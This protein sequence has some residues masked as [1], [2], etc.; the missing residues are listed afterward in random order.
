MN[1]TN[2]YESVDCAIL[3]R[4]A[5]AIRDS[6]KIQGTIYKHIKRQ[7]Y[8]D[9]PVSSLMRAAARTFG[10]EVDCVARWKLWPNL[11]RLM[12]NMDIPKCAMLALV[13]TL[14][15]AWCT[16]TR[17]HER[18]P[19]VAQCCGKGIDDLRHYLWCPELLKT[20][21]DVGR[22]RKLEFCGDSLGSA[23]SGLSGDGRFVALLWGSNQWRS[24]LLVNSITCNVYHRARHST[25]LIC[26]EA[27]RRICSHMMSNYAERD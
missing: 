12:Q 10:T 21:K 15:N 20:I 25:I 8:R 4:S 16:S 23:L 2:A 6:V 14:A 18:S 11:R 9:D 26:S 17:M 24:N 22:T 27:G 19:R 7:I 3:R 13:K 1:I 5:G